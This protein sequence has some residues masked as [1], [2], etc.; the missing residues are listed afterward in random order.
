MD[1]SKIVCNNCK[2]KNKSNAYNNGFYRCNIFK[3]NLCPLCKLNHNN[4][5]KIINYDNK[6]YIYEIHY[7]N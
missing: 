3:I 6:N 4:N 7:M 1:I 5:H 2:I